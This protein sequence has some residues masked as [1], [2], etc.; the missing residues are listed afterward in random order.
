MASSAVRVLEHHLVV[1]R[2]TW[3][4]SV[5]SSFLAPVLYLL[6]MGIG[7]GSIIDASPRNPRLGGASYLAF[8]APGLL[9]AAAMQTAA[10]ES[11]FP[12]MAGVKWLRTYHAM[13]AGPIGV[14][15]LVLGQFL[16][17]AFRIGTG[18]LAYLA[19][20]T[21]FGVVD[22]PLALLSPFAAV[23]CGMAF[24]GPIAAFAATQENDQSFALIFRL[25]V[26]PL[27]LFSGTFFPVSQLPDVVQ[28]VA[29]VTPLWH[30]VQL[31][32]GLVLGTLGLGEALVHIGY[33]AS[34]V[35][36]GWVV[37]QRT[38]ARRMAA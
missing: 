25:G 33:L 20:M 7:L 36:I 38:F 34:C 13:L 23:L 37:A 19:V 16:W 1:Y 3:R 14:R 29:W 8:V 28:P 24:A 2:A 4:G 17:M 31:T 26:L 6:A 22:S 32:R 11:M 30:G 12:I 10:S 35:A 21:L 27:F 18:A 9:A 15:D 5:V